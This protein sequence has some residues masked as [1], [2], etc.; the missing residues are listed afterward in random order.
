MSGV[1]SCHQHAAGRLADH[2]A[3]IRLGE[4]HTVCSQ[5]IDVR[6]FNFSLAV[7]ADFR[8]PQIVCH[9]ENDIR[10]LLLSGT[11][12]RGQKQIQTA[13]NCQQYKTTSKHYAI[14]FRMSGFGLFLK[15]L[16]PGD[17]L[18]IQIEKTL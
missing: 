10:F 4:L 17:V 3:G 1:L 13:E 9:D 2:A 8:I 15:D 12:D 11:G 7:T 16:H 14:P 5:L 18:K 6:G